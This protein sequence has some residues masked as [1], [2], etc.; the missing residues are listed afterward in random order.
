VIPAAFD[1][2]SAKYDALFTYT[3]LGQ[4]LRQRVWDSLRPHVVEGKSV[5]ELGCGTGEDA[6]WL[7]NQG[8]KVLATDV[9]T[10][11][12]KITA[13]K[14]RHSPN[15]HLL[16]THQLDLNAQM[17]IWPYET[18]FDGI[19][20]NFGAV[21]CTADWAGLARWLHQVIK[22]DGWV[23]LGVM[24]RFCLW[25]TVWHGFH[26]DFKTATRRWSGH[27]K[28]TL[29]SGK[30]LSVHYPTVRQLI[31]AFRPW[32]FPQKIIGLGLFV[33]PSDAFGVITKRPGVA[34]RLMRWEEKLAH[35]PVL[36]GWADH[37]W[38]EFAPRP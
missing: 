31:R 32:F 5:L 1:S 34:R 13:D 6:M 16:T 17:T 29:A 27:T 26:L 15:A 30:S 21:N 25:E 9:S 33:P 3:T 18:R 8:I 11:M 38:I 2:E 28:A 36:R 20:S 7:I 14:A 12:L 10:E 24:S 37:F 22:P 4:W 23:G 19:H 35:W